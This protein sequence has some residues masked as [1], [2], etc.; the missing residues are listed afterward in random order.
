MNKIRTGRWVV[1]A[2]IAMMPL[3][4]QSGLGWLAWMAAPTETVKPLFTLPEGKKVLVFTDDILNPVAYQQIKGELTDR[5][6]ARLMQKKLVAATVP[7][8]TFVAWASRTP[9]LDRLSVSEVG[10]AL[11]ADLVLYVHVDHLRLKEDERS[12]LWRGELATTVRVVDVQ[13][14][15]LWPLDRPEGYAVQQVETPTVDDPS[16]VY[17][18]E[19]ARQLAD[20]MSEAIV[21]LFCE[22]TVPMSAPPPSPEEHI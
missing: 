17:G 14:G 2:A 15:R 5:L 3:G 21:N 11:D 22:H 4:C 8:E 10:K 16:P 1:W 18:E 13:A 9:N 19:V 6:N 7:Y 12:T 20:A